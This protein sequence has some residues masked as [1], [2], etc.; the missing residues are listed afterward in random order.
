MIYKL[1]SCFP[2]VSVSYNQTN[3]HINKQT[4]KQPNRGGYRPGCR[5]GV[6]LQEA[7]HLVVQGRELVPGQ[8]GEQLGVQQ[9]LRDVAVVIIHFLSDSV[10]QPAQRLRCFCVRHVFSSTVTWR[11]R[12][13]HVTWSSCGILGDVVLPR[14]KRY[15]TCFTLFFLLKLIFYHQR[16]VINYVFVHYRFK[17]GYA[18][19]YWKRLH[20]FQVGNWLLICIMDSVGQVTK[21]LSK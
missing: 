17:T 2:D 4:N 14:P 20:H 21:L 12:V 19:I 3:K 8:L 7:P 10:Q 16:S 9:L 6:Y 15:L 1:K 13:D 18:V 5:C 11:D